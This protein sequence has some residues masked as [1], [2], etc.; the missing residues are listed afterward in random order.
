MKILILTS[1][2]VLIIILITGIYTM[3]KAKTETQKY[4]V[5]YIKEN[6]EIRYYPEAILATIEMKG[7]Y[8]NSRNSAFQVLAGYIFGGNEENTQIAMTSPV[9]MS[10]NE[11][12]NIMSFV[13]PSKMEFDNLSK[14]MD[15]RILLHKSKPMY[16]ASIQFGGYANEV[17]IARN[18][19]KL[20]EILKELKIQHTNQF[21]YLGY[22]SPFQ[23]VNRRNEVQVEIFDFK[24]ELL[25]KK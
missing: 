13:L 19:E 22:N 20:T 14:P 6:F 17:E 16:T 8:N 25:S 7:T 18:R 23:P 10:G 1:A 3:T 12:L 11:K 21:E 15:E 4:E 9:R 24:P 5:L 2:L